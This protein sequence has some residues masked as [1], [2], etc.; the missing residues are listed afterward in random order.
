MAKVFGRP[1]YVDPN[2]TLQPAVNFEV[3]C[4]WPGAVAT[5]TGFNG[6]MTVTMDGAFLRASQ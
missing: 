1:Y 6:R 2:V 4:K 5:P 3:L